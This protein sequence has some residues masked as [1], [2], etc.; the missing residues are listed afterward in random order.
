[1]VKHSD[2]PLSFSDLV[3]LVDHVETGN[4]VVAI[5]REHGISVIHT[6]GSGDDERE[7]NQDSRRKKLAF[8]KGDAR[9]KVTT[10]HSFKGWES[11]A[12]VVQVSKA[13]TMDSLALVYTA[14]TRLKMD[15]AGCYLTVVNS[16]AELESHGRTW[17]VWYAGVQTCVEPVSAT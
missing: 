11:K 16:T 5:L 8:Y 10:I 9:V 14:I 13:D 1:M 4:A 3:C 17:P 15:D 2:P 7:V 6:F 12:V